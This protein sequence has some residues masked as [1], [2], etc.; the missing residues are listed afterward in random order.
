MELVKG[1]LDILVLKAVTAEPK[2]GY[3]VTRWIRQHSEGLLDIEDAALYQSLHR[4]E[5]RGWLES[6][7]GRS[8]NNRRA[9]FYSLTPK[10]R[11][12]LKRQTTEIRRYVDALFQVLG[13][14]TA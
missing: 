3:A 6:K 5:R 9:K 2:H 10:G 4:M 13:A 7:W 8:E 14:E 1:T 12:E 11:A